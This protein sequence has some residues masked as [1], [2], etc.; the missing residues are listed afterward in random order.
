MIPKVD[1]AHDL[2]AQNVYGWAMDFRCK[3]GQFCQ[4]LNIAAKLSAAAIRCDS[5]MLWAMAPPTIL[6]EAMHGPLRVHAGRIASGLSGVA[7]EADGLRAQVLASC[8]SFP[9]KDLALHWAFGLRSGAGRWMFAQ[10]L[11]DL[12]MID[13]REMMQEG[14]VVK[15]MIIAIGCLERGLAASAPLPR[16]QIKFIKRAYSWDPQGCAAQIELAWS[17][18]CAVGLAQRQHGEVL[19]ARLERDLMRHVACRVFRGH[20]H[21]IR[22]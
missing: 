16:A 20:K 4:A 8:E 21:S 12:K 22:L 18:A 13:P 19:L 15:A 14:Q 10:K 17:R 1:F 3:K 5:L 2:F 6:A 9:D 7:E 11:I